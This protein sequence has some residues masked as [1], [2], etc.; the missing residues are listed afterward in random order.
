MGCLFFWVLNPRSAPYSNPPPLCRT[1]LYIFVPYLE[2]QN[3]HFLRAIC[4]KK[5][6]HLIKSEIQQTTGI[7]LYNAS[8][9]FH[10]DPAEVWKQI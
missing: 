10:N 2:S 4:K 1:H 8:V 3:S 7:R 5:K 6:Q 9:P